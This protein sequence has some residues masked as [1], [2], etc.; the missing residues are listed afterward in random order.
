LTTIATRATTTTRIASAP[1]AV[2]IAKPTPAVSSAS[3]STSAASAGMRLDHVQPGLMT[4]IVVIRPPIINPVA[5]HKGQSQDRYA[6]FENGVLFWQRGAAQAIAL[7]PRAKAPNGAKMAW[8]GA[9][10]AAIATPKIKQALA[11]FP[12]ATVLGVN[13]VGTTNYSFDGAG[14]HNRAHRLHVMLQGMR[15]AGSAPVAS[16][17]TVEVQAEI[18]FDPVDR[19]VVGYLSHWSIASS[20]GDFLGGGSLVRNVQQ[21][22]DPV[23]WS[24]FVVADVPATVDDPIAVLSVKTQADGDVVV[25]FEP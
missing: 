22:L 9:E 11:N 13:Y 4:D 20:Q 25:Y 24:Q 19:E 21:R 18:S 10:I 8:S 23:L 16:I 6:D 15:I 17:A 14:V 5:S 12:A 7:S 2:A 1:T 3:V